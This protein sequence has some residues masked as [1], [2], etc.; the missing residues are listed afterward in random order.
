MRK[1]VFGPV[2]S[3]R[4]GL[5]LGL[6]V[7][8]LKTCTFN[9]IYCQIGRT[10]SPT[11]ERRVY[12]DPEEV[13]AQVKEAIE[14]GPRP[15]YITFSGSGEPTLNS[16]LGVMINRIKRMTDIP[17]AVITNGSL[18]WMEEVRRDLKNADLV[19][20]SLDAAS[21]EVFK[22]INRP[23]PKLTIERVIDGLKRFCEEFEGKIW[24]EVM[25]V[26]GVNT[27]PEELRKLREVIS[28][29]D[30]DKIQLNTPVRPPA[31]RWV[32]A[33]GRG[34]M[35]EI[36]AFFGEKAEVI[37]DFSKETP[38]IYGATESAILEMLLRRPCT[39]EEISD[40]LGIPL[41]EVSD[42]LKAMLRRGIIREREHAGRVYYSGADG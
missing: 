23:A 2:P 40:S 25:L 32:K 1:A 10:P 17:V 28:S 13:I 35:E 14:R 39:A 7:I 19:M 30:V 11:I 3:R 9:C 26:E 27:D 8:P 24:L 41:P 18:L 12:V 38:K 20:P 36:A 16:A 6:D 5:S 15:D 4:L 21:E 22:R 31:E 42:R 33:L 37:A 34:R 29:L